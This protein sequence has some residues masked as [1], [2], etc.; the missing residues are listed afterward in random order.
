MI[1]TITMTK[2]IPT[3][4]PA[5]TLASVPPPSVVVMVV[6]VVSS[7]TVVSVVVPTVIK[8]HKPYIKFEVANNI[9]VL[10]GV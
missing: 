7:E 2:P 10:A 4:T 1:T 5:I 6:V 9:F 3:S 8:C